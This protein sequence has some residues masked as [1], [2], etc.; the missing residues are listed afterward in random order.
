MDWGLGRGRKRSAGLGAPPLY[1]SLNLNLA[2]KPRRMSR[3]FPE[4]GACL[5]FA[6]L[7]SLG[8]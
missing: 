3:S 7:T 1:L 6:S 4:W 2:A 5:K 8:F